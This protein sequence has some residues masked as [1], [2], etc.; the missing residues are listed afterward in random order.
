VF[1]GDIGAFLDEAGSGSVFGGIR[2]LLTEQLERS[3]SSEQDV[4]RVLAVEREP[5]TLTELLAEL[6][7]RVGRGAVV[8]AV[9]ALRRRSLVERVERGGAAAFTLQSVV[10][11]Y[12][13]DRLLE[14]VCDEIVL[15][16]PTLL[17]AQHLIKARTKD[18]VRNTQERLIGEPI[19]RRLQLE[20]GDRGVDQP[21]LGLLE[22]WRERPPEVQGCGP[23][24]VVNLLRL[25]HGD[26][27]GV[28]LT[29]LS[30]R[31][32]YLA[33]IEMHDASLAGTHFSDVV[34]A[35]AFSFPV[36][37]ALS[38][39]GASLVA[40]TAAGEVWLWRV[41][42]R[43]PRRQPGWHGSAVGR[44]WRA[45]DCHIARAQWPCLDRGALR[46]WAA[47]SQRQRR[48]DGPVV[49]DEQR[50]VSTHPAQGSSLRAHGHRRRDRRDS[51]PA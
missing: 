19:L 42:D 9:E 41:E 32:T 15:G 40:G 10:L 47:R 13:T 11:E 39:D 38:G 18:Y 23:G 50:R 35:D 6:G 45:T 26:L 51:S 28:N 4:L 46:R 17:V 30:I 14:E 37:V 49:G 5:V 25:E 20:L 24:N 16:K 29:R 22:G 12:V 44:E 8:E 3:S 7:P 31:Q 36:A 43:T 34:L 21:L 33:G 1:G 2:R 48:R 27:R